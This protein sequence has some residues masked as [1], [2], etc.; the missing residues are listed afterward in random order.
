MG[1]E[2][3][4]VKKGRCGMCVWGQCKGAG[5]CVGMW[6]RWGRAGGRIK[7]GGHT[8]FMGR[9]QG[10]SNNQNTSRPGPRHMSPGPKINVPSNI[11]RVREVRRRPNKIN[12][13]GKGEG[14]RGKGRTRAREGEGE[15]HL[16]NQNA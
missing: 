9:W 4:N 13:V 1:Q 6:G 8:N 3:I 15:G 16:S 12:G 7:R 11:R 14:G 10:R 5:T 2:E